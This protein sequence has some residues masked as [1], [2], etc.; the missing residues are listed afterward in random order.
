MKKCFL[1]HSSKDKKRYVEAVARKLPKDWRVYDEDTFESGMKTLDEISRLLDETGL[2][3][4]FISDDALKSDW[5]RDELLGAKKRLD[6][7]SVSRILPI[8]IDRSVSHED[9]RIP[10]WM[11]NEYNLRAVSKSAVA[12]RQIQQKLRELSWVE[13]P[14]LKER[15]QIFVGRNEQIATLEQ[16]FDDYSKCPATAIICSG[17]PLIGRKSLL[18]HGLRKV[19]LIKDSYSPPVITMTPQDSIEDFIIKV[20]DLGYS[21][22]DKAK[23]LLEKSMEEKLNIA[24]ALCNDLSGAAEILFVEDSGGLVT[25]EREIVQWF[26]KLIGMLSGNEKTMFAIAA[27]SRPDFSHVRGDQLFP[28][29][30]QELNETERMGL[31][32]RLSEFEDLDLKVADFNHF[33]GVLYGFPD[34]VQYAITLIKELG[35]PEAKKRTELLV[36]FNSDRVAKLVDIYAPSVEDKQFL[37]VL[38]EFD[39]ISYDFLEKLIDLDL[40]SAT[41]IRLLGAAIC[42]TVGSTGEYLRL[43]D[44][45]RDYMRRLRLDLPESFEQRL[46][47]HVQDFI[48]KQ[49]AEAVDASE[50][51]F[52]VKKALASGANVDRSLLVPSHFLNAMKELYDRDK[53]YRQVVRLADR[54]LQSEASMDGNISRE[55]RYFL[56]QSLARQKTARFLEE[57]RKISGPEHQFLMGFYYRMVGRTSDAIGRQ[58]EASKYSRT[59]SRARREL[60]HLY[61]GME[62]YAAAL[63]LAQRNYHDRPSNIFHIQAYLECLIHSKDW[64][65]NQQKMEILFTRLKIAGENSEKAEEMWMGATALYLAICESDINRALDVA[66]DAA[67]KFPHSPYPLFT[68]ASLLLRAGKDVDE[69]SIVIDKL[70]ALSSA[71]GLFEGSVKKLRAQLH[72]LRGEDDLA[73]TELNGYLRNIPENE[74]SSAEA[75]IKSLEFIAPYE[76]DDLPTV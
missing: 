30:V 9:T 1:S 20:F 8:V 3:V 39:F 18:R 37:Y 29:H 55:I 58:L 69:L 40:H 15:Q 63:D 67:A 34:Q 49:D 52:T 56:C 72:Y 38:S 14:K 50:Y 31:F 5:V 11:R 25:Y 57:V 19:G 66:G 16:R 47:T 62:D 42:E 51:L 24:K 12:A 21:D 53:N 26:K 2:F 27:R 41:L 17:L 70:S 75:R 10:E 46:K 64:A 28:I 6:G 43:N 65:G 44:S 60:V 45:I 23:N 36:D 7:G 4:V 74:R 54:V 76:Q 32:K 35:L 48:E 61:I 22:G 33:S 13:H 59:A 71:K 68:K 73:R